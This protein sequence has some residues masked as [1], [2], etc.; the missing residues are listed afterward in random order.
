M[1]I[2][3][4]RRMLIDG[5]TPLPHN[6]A[7]ESELLLLGNSTDISDV[8]EFIEKHQRGIVSF[9]PAVV[10]DA[11]R[12]IPIAELAEAVIKYNEYRNKVF[13]P[14][15]HFVYVKLETG[16]FAGYD[17]RLGKLGERV[18]PVLRVVIKYKGKMFDSFIN[19]RGAEEVISEVT[20]THLEKTNTLTNAL[21]AT[22]GIAEVNAEIGKFFDSVGLPKHMPGINRHIHT[23]SANTEFNSKF[24]QCHLPDLKRRCG[25]SGVDINLLLTTMR[26]TGSVIPPLNL[27]RDDPLSYVTHMADIHEKIIQGLKYV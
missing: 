6:D 8:D 4:L 12:A 15:N 27:Y 18:Y 9:Y 19:P 17:G 3:L 13:T 7:F 16:G 21:K 20:K 10:R 14:D 23:V 24:I 26:S 22:N 5:V 1:N 11:D 2:E 25:P